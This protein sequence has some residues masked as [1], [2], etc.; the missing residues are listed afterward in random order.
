MY[1]ESKQKVTNIVALVTNVPTVLCHLKVLSVLSMN[2][3]EN[4]DV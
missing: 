4:V 1:R 3:S 2:C